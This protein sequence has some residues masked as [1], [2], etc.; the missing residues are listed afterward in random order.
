MERRA[1]LKQIEDKKRRV[2]ELRARKAAR[3]VA[4]QNADESVADNTLKSAEEAAAELRHYVDSLVA[5]SSDPTPTATHAAAMTPS[6]LQEDEEEEDGKDDE[7]TVVSAKEHDQKVSVQVEVYE[8]WTQTAGLDEEQAVKDR[9]SELPPTEEEKEEQQDEKN[10]QQT[11]VLQHPPALSHDAATLH[12]FVERSSRLV[13]RC[14]GEQRVFDALREEEHTVAYDEE[15]ERNEEHLERVVHAATFRAS[16][17]VSSCAFSPHRP[18]AFI[19][20]YTTGSKVLD[21]L[22]GKVDVWSISRSSPE[23]S[24]GCQS[25]ATACAFSPC[26]PWLVA[27]GTRCGQVAYWDL[28]SASRM[29]AHRSPLDGRCPHA[30]AVNFLRV[31]RDQLITAAED[32]TVA[33]WAPGQLERPV[34]QDAILDDHKR[35]WPLSALDGPIDDGDFLGFLAATDDGRLKRVTLFT[36]TSDRRQLD[37]PHFGCIT[38]LAAHPSARAE[39]SDARLHDANGL[40]RKLFLST[41]FDWSAAV[42][43]A[44]RPI[45]TLDHGPHNYLAHADWS[46]TNPTLFAT[47]AADGVLRFWTLGSL[48]PL[49]PSATFKASNHALNKFAFS[50]DGRRM[51]LADLGGSLSLLKLDDHLSKS[52]ARRDSKLDDA[53]AANWGSAR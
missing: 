17:G 6:L 27:A 26:E 1:R 23:R 48:D 14:L 22:E 3:T 50:H 37:S 7:R 16:R 42:W 33:A 18:D 31:D 10:E 46:P 21:G 43:A 15:L 47:A 39:A 11:T 53:L 25:A 38:A 51:L 29:P 19:S 36:S 34:E 12:D 45:L 9:K 13:E 24:L 41:C 44:D 5:S 4:K 40:R 32:G 35:P 28:R 20:A 8:K 2:E 49:V 52:D 30:G